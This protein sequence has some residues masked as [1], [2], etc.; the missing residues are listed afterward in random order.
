MTTT[1]DSLAENYDAGR[2]GYAPEIYTNLVANGLN[3]RYRVLD[4]G[5]GTGLASAPLIGWGYPVTG[6][7]PSEPMLAHAKRRF[8]TAEW[9]VGTA[10][11]LPFKDGS[12]DAVISA[13]TMHRV[14]RAAAMKEV[15]RVVRKGGLVGIWWK[16]LMSDDAVKSLRDEAASEIGIAPPPAGLTGGF[17]E[18][19]ATP[20]TTHAIRVVPWRTSMP[21]SQIVE[22]ER[23]RGNVHDRMG[24][25]YDA[26]IKIFERRL[27]ERFGEGDPYVPLAYTHY[28][29]IATK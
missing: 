19:Y 3:Q 18:F 23:S 7:D 24:E 5:C 28:L 20:F 6:I 16:H 14:D 25:Q 9:V 2:I 8:P 12:F 26:Y 15:F 17:K 4:V 13:Q 22:M 27:H 21:L 1:F 29:Y 10:E 11:A